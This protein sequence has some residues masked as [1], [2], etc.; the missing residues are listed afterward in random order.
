MKRFA[1]NVLVFF[2]SL[3][4][5]VVVGIILLVAYLFIISNTMT[6]EQQSNNFILI[7]CTIGVGG[8]VAMISFITGL[9]CWDTFNWEYWR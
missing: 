5:A 9:W 1:F 7:M 6:L 2:L 4:S 3:L 8:L